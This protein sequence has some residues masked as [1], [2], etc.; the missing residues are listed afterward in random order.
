MPYVKVICEGD[1]VTIV[2]KVQSVFVTDGC[3]DVVN[4]GGERFIFAALH[5]MR[6]YRNP[7][8]LKVEDNAE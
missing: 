2:D 5:W 8:D 3:L 4:T 6:A 1:D 7:D